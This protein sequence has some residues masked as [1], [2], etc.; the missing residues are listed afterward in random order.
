[1][2]A[3]RLHL[4]TPHSDNP[5]S[6][7]NPAPSSTLVLEHDVPIPQPTEPGQM[8]IRVNATTVIRDALTWPETY[9]E[10]FRILGHDFSGT[11]VSTYKEQNAPFKP[12]DEVYGMT[13]ATRAG[14]WAEYAI[15]SAEEACLKPSQLTWA[16]AAAVPLS[17]LTAYQALFEKAGIVPPDF[18]TSQGHSGS[19][20]VGE[21]PGRCRVLVTGAAGC[22]GLYAVQLARLAGL[23][24]VAAT[25]SNSRNQ[26]LL[27]RLGADEV[28]EYGD[29]SKSPELFQIVI[30]TTGGEVLTMCWKLVSTDGTLVSVDSASYDFV[31]KHRK[32]GIADGKGAVKAMFFIVSPSTQAL[33]R[34]AVALDRRLLEPFVARVM[35]LA[36]ARMAYDLCETVR[37]ERGKIV[38]IPRH[39]EEAV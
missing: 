25:S 13:S 35:P 38:L 9:A 23:H 16:E 39:G 32:S 34:L 31:E 11:V 19:H 4:K 14:T 36:D 24:V 33:G 37:T 6:V 27:H 30:D 22:V 29:L 20:E 8:L 7:F 17:A 5:Y 21:N 12:G 26:S 3:V 10:E 28:V 1:M 18:H 2:D 15:V